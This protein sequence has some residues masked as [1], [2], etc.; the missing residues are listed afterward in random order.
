MAKK[1]SNYLKMILVAGV[2]SGIMT[3]VLNVGKALA[4]VSWN[5]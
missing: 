4:S 1:T 5:F 2:V 3:I